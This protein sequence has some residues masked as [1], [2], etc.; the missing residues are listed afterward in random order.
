M[1]PCHRWVFVKQPKVLIL[2]M[3]QPISAY[4][5][6]CL[7]SSHSCPFLVCQLLTF[8]CR[9][10]LCLRHWV[11]RESFKNKTKHPFLIYTSL[12]NQNS[13]LE[14]N[15]YIEHSLPGSRTKKKWHLQLVSKGNESL[16]SRREIQVNMKWMHCFSKTRE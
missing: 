1:L 14:P 2:F 13:C 10:T 6:S 5:P 15:S 11:I 4:L 16:V 7:G 9:E 8:F 3:F 12:F